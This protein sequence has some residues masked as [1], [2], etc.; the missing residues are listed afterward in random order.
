MLKNHLQSEIVRHLDLYE[1]LLKQHDFKRAGD[2]YSIYMYELS[3]RLTEDEVIFKQVVDELLF[4]HNKP[5]VQIEI[6]TEAIGMNYRRQEA[7]DLLEKIAAWTS[8][9]TLQSASGKVCNTAQMR[10]HNLLGYPY[11]MMNQTWQR[12]EKIAI[13]AVYQKFFDDRANNG[14]DVREQRVGFTAHHKQIKLSEITAIYSNDTDDFLLACRAMTGEP[15]Y[16]LTSKE[17]EF[18]AAYPSFQRMEPFKRNG[19]IVFTEDHTYG[20]LMKNG[21]FCIPPIY[22]DISR[23]S[24]TFFMSLHSPVNGDLYHH[25]GKIL[26]KNI[27]PFDIVTGECATFIYQNN[28]YN[29]EGQRI[30]SLAS[31]GT[32]WQASADLGEY[33]GFNAANEVIFIEQRGKQLELDINFDT[34]LFLD[35]DG[36]VCITTEHGKTTLT[37]DGKAFLLDREALVLIKRFSNEHFIVR[38]EWE[39]GPYLWIDRKKNKLHFYETIIC[40]E[41]DYVFAQKRG[42]AFWLVIDSLG[43]TCVTEKKQIIQIDEQAQWMLEDAKLERYWLLPLSKKLIQ[44]QKLVKQFIRKNRLT[45]SNESPQD[46]NVEGET[47]HVQ[48]YK[49]D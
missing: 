32:D 25:T 46:G 33:A 11:D 12:P 27:A 18:I 6:A 26:L 17:G 7:I 48:K 35:Q 31:L 40:P 37:M 5:H 3:K 36:E 28:L 10:L 13:T 49:N 14:V 29:E 47:I 2:I 38:G 19:S 44:K 22:Q 42:S 15:R 8:D 39:E 21:D 1:E 9:M 41:A 20:V 45:L 43:K 23:L 30:A 4:L 34:Q 16:I 24:A